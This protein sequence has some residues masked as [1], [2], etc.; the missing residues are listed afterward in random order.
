LIE[1]ELPEGPPYFPEDTLTDRSER[2][3]IAELIREKAYHLFSDEIPYSVAV[4]TEEVVERNPELFYVRAVI[5][6]EKDSQKGILIGQ[7]GKALKRLGQDTRPEIEALLGRKVY[8]EL[9]VKVKNNWRKDN[10]ALR[11][12]GME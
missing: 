3:L 5:Y 10:N 1:Q 6:V 4:V 12:L 8:L 11:Q 7:N 2:F 9:W